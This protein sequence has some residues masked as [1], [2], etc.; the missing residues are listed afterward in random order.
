MAL[1]PPRRIFTAVRRR[2][3]A[4]RRT[5][6]SPRV[7]TRTPACPAAA[8]AH[9]VDGLVAAQDDE[10]SSCRWARVRCIAGAVRESLQLEVGV[11]VQQRCFQRQSISRGRAVQCLP[12]FARMTGSKRRRAHIAGRGRSMGATVRGCHAAPMQ[13]RKS[14]RA[15]ARHGTRG[16]PRTESS[17]CR[18]SGRPAG[19]DE[20]PTLRARWRSPSCRILVALEWAV[21]FYGVAALVAERGCGRR[22]ARSLAIGSRAGGRLPLVPLE[23]EGAGTARGWFVVPRCHE[24][25][26]HSAGAVG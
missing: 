1:T 19:D 22:P 20:R 24:R 7:G 15:P 8:V 18:P 9:I 14:R 5:C 4:R 17:P 10:H 11:E 2:G 12:T 3:R 16:S 25:S 21:R 13:S 6:P 26:G 23:P